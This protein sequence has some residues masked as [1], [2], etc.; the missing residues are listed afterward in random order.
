MF[1]IYITLS[2]KENIL[3]NRTKHFGCL[4]GELI[5]LIDIFVILLYFNACLI[6]FIWS[7]SASQAGPWKLFIFIYLA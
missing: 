2:D 6:F 3:P 1:F 5:G 7:R 4:G